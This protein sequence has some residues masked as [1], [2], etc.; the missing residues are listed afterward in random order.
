MR[1]WK[2]AHPEAVRAHRRLRRER[3]PSLL[4]TPEQLRERRL[5]RFGLTVAAYDTMH[6]SQG[7]RCAVCHSEPAPNRRLA[8]DHC[9]DSGRVRGLLCTRCNIALGWFEKHGNLLD[10]MRAYLGGNLPHSS[11]SLGSLSTSP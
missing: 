1:R 10:A 9:H 3:N 8:V 6:A 4:R 11:A 5:A 7:G 2:A